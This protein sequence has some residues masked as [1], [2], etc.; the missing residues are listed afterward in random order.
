MG[1][2]PDRIKLEL[3]KSDNWRVAKLLSV[4]STKTIQKLV[5]EKT[6]ARI[7]FGKE[8]ERRIKYKIVQADHNEIILERED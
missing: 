3:L 5:E 1:K 2:A 7:S 4:L 6:F 8:R